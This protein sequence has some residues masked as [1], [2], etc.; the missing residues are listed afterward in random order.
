M[1]AV[2]E[3]KYLFRDIVIAWP[4]S[5]HDARVLSNSQIFKIGEQNKLFPEDYHIL[6]LRK[7]MLIVNVGGKF[8]G[9]VILGDPAYPLLPWLLKPYPENLNTIP[10]HQRF[11]YRLSRARGT[12]E[13]AFGRWKGRFC[14]FPKESGHG[15]K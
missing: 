8:I 5:I 4:G 1:Q 2:V 6:K 11:N 12:V 15:Y 9:P 14:R 10:Q 3:C 13:N 7:Q